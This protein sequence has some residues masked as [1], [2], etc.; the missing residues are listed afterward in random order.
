[1][2]GS[3]TEQAEMRGKKTSSPQRLHG[4][5]HQTQDHRNRQSYKYFLHIS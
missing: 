2:L 1:M 5:Y 4:K 3:G